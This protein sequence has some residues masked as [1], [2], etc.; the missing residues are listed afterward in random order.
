MSAAVIFA[1]GPSAPR[2]DVSLLPSGAIII[3]ADSGLD[4]ARRLG[5]EPTILVGDLDSVSAEGLRWAEENGIVIDKHPADKDETD[6]ELA[7]SA[8]AHICDELIVV[9]GGQG[10]ADHAFANLALLAAPRFAGVEL[11]AFVGDAVVTVIRS[12]RELRGGVGDLVSLFALGS[13][14][15]G[16]SSTGLRW[17]LREADLEPGSTLGVS[18]EFAA[19]EATVDVGIGVVLAIQ[20]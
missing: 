2:L 18:N 11:S 17:P 1:G 5:L 14:A 15:S 8:A 10:R 12:H 16:V 19:S 13:I 9:D 4:H 7:L 20:P 6:L 3:A